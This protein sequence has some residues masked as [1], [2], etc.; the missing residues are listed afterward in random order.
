M[1][2][3]D[4][5][6]VERSKQ[7]DKTSFGKLVS[8]HYD[9]VYAV[10]FGILRNREE[11]LDVTQDVFFKVFRDIQKFIGQS[12][13]KTWLYRV[14]ANG[15]IDHYRKRRPL[16]PIEDEADFET[17]EVSPRESASRRE[18]REL[19]EEA[20]DL[21][22]PEQRAVFVLRE[23]NELSYEEIAESL[24]IEIGTVMSRLFYA[25][26]KLAQILGIKLKDN[27]HE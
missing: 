13:F 11:A 16:E 25:R 2:D 19:V 1:S 24:Q 8:K 4:Q 21:L 15:A 23:W 22:N 6:L 10:I 27:Q 5:D 18:I 17:K 14:A 7:G 12:K 20:L 9:M 3:P 26:K